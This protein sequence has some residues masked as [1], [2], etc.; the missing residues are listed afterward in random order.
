MGWQ[1]MGTTG[2]AA[3]LFAA[4]PE[5]RLALLRSVWPAAVG[6]EVA[7]NTEVVTL[8]REALRI[9][10]RDAGWRR[11]LFR[12]RSDILGR[13]RSLAGAAAPRQ[14]GFVD[15]GMAALPRATAIPAAPPPAVAPPSIVAAADAIV[16]DEIR[17]RFLASA[18]QYLERASQP[19]GRARKETRHA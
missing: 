3:A 5:R 15:G 11:V 14:L 4:T 19:K 2:G 16:D 1:R 17:A 18:A 13:L 6:P 8:D 7:R 12:M 9:R 10:V